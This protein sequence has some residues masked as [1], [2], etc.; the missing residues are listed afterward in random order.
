MSG[1]SLF[2]ILRHCV[3]FCWKRRKRKACR[4]IFCTYSYAGRMFPSENL[5]F[6]VFDTAKAQAQAQVTS[7]LAIVL[8][9]IGVH[10]LQQNK[11]NKKTK[12][13]KRARSMLAAKVPKRIERRAYFSKESLEG[14]WSI[15]II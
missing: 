14:G 15:I 2:V 5:S 1:G 7:K 13:Q 3:S 10:H 9:T 4:G 12:G 8:L 11:P 6:F